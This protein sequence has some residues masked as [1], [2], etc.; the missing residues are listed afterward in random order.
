MPVMQ[1]S[2]G[3][4]H[5]NEKLWR[6]FAKSSKTPYNIDEHTVSRS[7]LYEYI[8]PT[9][10]Q[11][12]FATFI[13]VT[14]GLKPNSCCANFAVILAI[15]Q[16]LHHLRP[17]WHIFCTLI[18]FPRQTKSG[19]LNRKQYSARITRKMCTYVHVYIYNTVYRDSFATQ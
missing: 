5:G 14:D 19:N 2:L 13:L 12:Y 8:F 16:I 15:M 1:T 4:L 10:T 7:P 17:D 18:F 9:N 6:L 11:K 3:K